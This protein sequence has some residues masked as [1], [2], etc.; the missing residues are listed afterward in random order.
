[1]DREPEGEAM[2]SK[3]KSTLQ[4]YQCYSHLCLLHTS[5]L[6]FWRKIEIFNMEISTAGSPLS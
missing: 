2:L 5:S 3:L 1:M 4:E 6:E